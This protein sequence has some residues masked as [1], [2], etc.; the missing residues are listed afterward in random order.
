MS[1]PTSAYESSNEGMDLTDPQT[2][3]L[4]QCATPCHSCILH[5]NTEKRLLEPRSLRDYL[6]RVAQHDE[7]VVCHNTVA[8]LGL[9]ESEPAICAGYMSEDVPVDEQ[10]WRRSFRARLIKRHGRTV[11][12]PPPAP[13]SEGTEVPQSR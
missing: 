12:V 5:P 13:L 11:A 4:R 6:D 3:L 9:G 1:N 8:D 10:E 7:F 2:G